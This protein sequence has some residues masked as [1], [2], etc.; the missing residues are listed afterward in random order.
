M[1]LDDIQKKLRKKA[2]AYQKE[3]AMLVSEPTQINRDRYYTLKGALQTIQDILKDLDG[4][5]IPNERRKQE[6]RYQ[7]QKQKPIN[8]DL[9]K[10]LYKIADKLNGD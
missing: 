3:S 6:R 9:A 2:E 5:K 4:V 1:G 7:N 10:M 8:D